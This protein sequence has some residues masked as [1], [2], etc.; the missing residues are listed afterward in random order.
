MINAGFNPIHSVTVTDQS[1][2]LRTVQV[3]SEK[4]LTLFMNDDKIVT[5]MTLGTHPKALAIG[6][7]INQCLIK[8]IQEIQSIHVNHET[9]QV[10]TV[11]DEKTH[12]AVTAGCGQGVKLSFNQLPNIHCSKLKIQKTM[13]DALLYTLTQQNEIHRQAGGVHSCALCQGTEIIAFV[14]DVG[15]HNAVDTIAGLMWL[16]N[17]LGFDKI[18]YTTGRLT[19]EMVMKVA[20]L[21]IGVLLSRSGVTY[22]GI[23]NAQEIGMTLIAHAK[24]RQFL[25]FSGE[26]NVI[27]D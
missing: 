20:H 15:R 27:F 4:P 22:K 7:L 6:Y 17:W 9:I 18:F 5:L 2:Q 11:A 14:E 16:H 3:A 25:I 1:G 24:G 26:K 12:C 13:I 23:Q 10:T 8:Q 19:S 21:G